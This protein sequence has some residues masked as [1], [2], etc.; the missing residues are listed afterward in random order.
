MG[1]QKYFDEEPERERIRAM[2]VEEFAARVVRRTGGGTKQVLHA[3]CDPDAEAEKPLC[4]STTVSG[5]WDNKSLAVYPIQHRDWCRRC[6]I[7]MFPERS[8][9][10]GAFR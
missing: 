9:L 3:P 1:M 10:E 6:L 4:G 7:R 5:E 2:I 8:N